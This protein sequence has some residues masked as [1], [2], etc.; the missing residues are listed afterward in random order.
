MRIS[1]QVY[2]VDLVDP[3]GK[4]YKLKKIVTDKTY[5]NF[6]KKAGKELARIEEEKRKKERL[7]LKHLYH[8]PYAEENW[9]DDDQNNLNL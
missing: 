4:K 2:Y 1:S 5:A 3:E 8:D 9:E 7:K 6:T